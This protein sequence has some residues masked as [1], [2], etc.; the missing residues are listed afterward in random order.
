[1]LAT[2]AVTLQPIKNPEPP[3]LLE[4]Q[5]ELQPHEIFERLIRAN[6][7]FIHLRS[8]IYSRCAKEGSSL[9]SARSWLTNPKDTIRIIGESIDKRSKEAGEF[10]L[11][12]EDF[13]NFKIGGVNAFFRSA[14][15]ATLFSELITNYERVFREEETKDGISSSYHNPN[16]SVAHIINDGLKAV[17]KRYENVHAED[18]RL[19]KELADK[20]TG[21]N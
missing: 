19:L 10:G 18:F 1:M 16:F 5:K 17:Y 12:E 2:R 14:A 11:S 8:D 15:A 4:N 9:I 7:F 20:V 21:I 6:D 13:S 3:K